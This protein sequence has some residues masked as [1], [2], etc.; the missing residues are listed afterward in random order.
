METKDFVA[1]ARD[2]GPKFAARAADHDANDT[3][4]AENYA[5]MKAAG[6]FTAAVPTELG[7][8]GAS[9]VEMCGVV[10]EMGRH[11]ASTALAFAMHTH[12]VATGAMSWRGGNK[13]PE[14]MLRK[15]GEGA[16]LVTSGGS[17]W[18]PGSGKLEKVE[19][20][21]RMT[22]RKIFGSG[23]PAGQIFATCG[24]YDDPTE[25]PTVVHFPIPMTAPGLKVLDT[26]R[27][28]GMRGTGSNDIMLQSVFIPD[29]AM[30]GLRRPAGQWHP[31]FHAVTMVALPVVYSAYLG[32]A[33]TA[34]GLALEMAQKRKND[35]ATAYLVGEMENNLVA[36]QV[37]YA[38]ALELLKTARPGPETTSAILIRRTLM[39]GAMLRTVEKAMEVAGGAS[40][41]RAAQLERLFRD[42]Q[43]ARFHP[44]QEK[45]QTRLTGRLLLGLGI[46]G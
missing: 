40:F 7:G 6:L 31:F 45:P 22:G 30:G 21:Y 44:L 46:D 27:T 34:R 18:L 29:A 1:V 15:V 14:G 20:G 23:G 4:V 5:E 9:A 25:G 42:I 32:V 39:A 38:S 13:M 3:F 35:D 10:R 8:A 33:E 16:I 41:Y 2:L 19:G 17:D 12:P 11:C 37:A 43:A 28:L 36:A 24:I 26:W